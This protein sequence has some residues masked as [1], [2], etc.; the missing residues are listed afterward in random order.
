MTPK[1][2]AQNYLDQIAPKSSLSSW[3]RPGWRLLVLIGAGAL[4]IVIALSITISAINNA[5][6]TPWQELSAKLDATEIVANS[7][8]PHLKS[9]QLRSLNSELKLHLTNI[10]RDSATPFQLAGIDVKKLPESVTKQESADTMLAELE[11]GR[12]K[13]QYDSVYVREMTAQLG[14]LL[15]LLSQIYLSTNNT[16][17]QTFLTTAYNNI[18]PIYEALS[19]TSIV[20]S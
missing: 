5:R 14:S 6:R 20:S 10:K 8:T 18:E 13:A 2:A 19:N 1:P 17:L 11:E 7:A 15:A 3:L 9:G 16:E 4:I 12:L